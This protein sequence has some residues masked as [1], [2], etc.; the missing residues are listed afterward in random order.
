MAP[1]LRRVTDQDL[2]EWSRALRTGFL[3]PP[4]VTKEEI[5]LRTAAVATGRVQGVFDGA[6]C[7]ATFRSF[8]QRLTLP[9]GADIAA[10]AVSNVTVSPT[11]RRRGLLSRM[12]AADLRA[13]EERGATAATLIAAEYPIYGRYGF[14]PV[15]W[16]TGW[17]VDVA[18]TGLDR[19][20]AGPADGARV[21]LVDPADVR[22]HGPGLHER[23]RATRHGVI[24][25]IERWWLVNT[26]A[27]P[28]GIPWE[29]PYYVLHRSA[30]GTVDGLL[31]YTAEDTWEGMNPQGVVTVLDLVAVTPGAERAL[32]HHV[33]SI[34]L[35]AKVRTGHR[36]PDDLLPLL[37][38]DPRAARVTHHSDFLWLRPLDVPTL[39]AARTYASSGSLVLGVTD[40]GGP[41]DGRFLLEAGPDGARCV[42]TTRAADLVLGPGELG[43]LALGDE[44]AARLAELGRVDEERAGA[45]ALTDALFRTARRP[46]CP[47]LF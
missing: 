15:T 31:V 17:E 34:D 39:L 29:E 13:A 26:G 40:P 11:H 2:P 14:G 19:R 46:W 42:P 43:S 41:A 28:T 47:D 38:P 27:M 7:V 1:E 18:R 45:V 10:N 37:M 21:D 6:R 22:V 23:L 3:R 33:L 24:D 16:T 36:A 20:Y 30:D 44:S 35:V 4:V 12:M 5:E 8:D 9:G 25:R 32:W